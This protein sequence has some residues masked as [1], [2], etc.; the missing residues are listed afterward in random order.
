MRLWDLNSVRSIKFVMNKNLHTN[1]FW[2]TNGRVRA[3]HLSAAITIATHPLNSPN[4]RH[5]TWRKHSPFVKNLVMYICVPVPI[6]AIKSLTVKHRSIKR[7]F[8]FRRYSTNKYNNNFSSKYSD[9]FQMLSTFDKSANGKKWYRLSDSQEKYW[10]IQYDF[11]S[12]KLK[13]F[14]NIW[15]SPSITLIFSYN[16]KPYLCAREW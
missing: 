1:T 5:K 4:K 14:E 10:K 12:W 7:C 3:N 6:M 2:Y 16:N 8:R 15:M 11:H 13:L 9:H